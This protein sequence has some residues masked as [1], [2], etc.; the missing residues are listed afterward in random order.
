[1]HRAPISEQRLIVKIVILAVWVT[2]LQTCS[3]IEKSLIK[4]QLLIGWLCLTQCHLFAYV[5][6]F[7][8]DLFLPLCTDFFHPVLPFDLSFTMISEL[9]SLFVVVFLWIWNHFVLL[10]FLHFFSCFLS[11]PSQILLLFQVLFVLNAFLNFCSFFD[12]DFCLPFS[13]I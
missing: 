12:F 11:C 10:D 2:C 13:H 6:F 7:P 8:L 9:L 4:Q 3:V 5:S 1:M